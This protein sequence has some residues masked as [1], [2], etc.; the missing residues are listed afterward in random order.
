[1]VTVALVVMGLATVTA[2][3]G[4]LL[5]R[6]DAQLRNIGQQVA[7]Q[8]DLG[9]NRILFNLPPTPDSGLRLP[10]PYVL[11]AWG[12]DGTLVDR[13]PKN[14][15]LSQAPM[16]SPSDLSRN[17][18]FIA[19]GGGNRWRVLVVPGPDNERIVIAAAMTD[20]DSAVSRLGWL[21]LSVGLALLLFVAVVGGI[22]VRRSLRPLAEI[23]KTAGAIADGDLSQRIPERAPQTEVGRLGRALNSMLSQIE[24]AFAA[25]A[26]SEHRALQSEERMRQF[27]A[28]A[29][30][31]LRTPL[32]TIRGFAEL[33]R[34]GAGEP[35]Q[36]IKRI[37]DDA[38]R[39]GLLVEDLLLLARLDQQRP[40]VMEPVELIVLANDAVQAARALAPDRTITLVVAPIVGASGEDRG[41]WVTGDE[42]RLRQ[43]IDNL[44]GNALAHTPPESPVTI[45]LSVADGLAV[46]E[47]ADEGPG[48]TP[49]QSER[50]FERF[51]RADPARSRRSGN[52]GTGLGL[53]IVAAL[54]AAHGG[55]VEVVSAPGAGAT[56]RVRLPLA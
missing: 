48:L 23:E 28:D 22:M 21:I 14:I 9:G 55:T 31:E 29:S 2:L 38:A 1:M 10:S 15:V 12:A 24:A 13:Y 50:V 20:V 34:Q 3:R 19:S 27:V 5:D 16:V 7:S 17:E 26:A 45:S 25:R 37:E 56:F 11:E 52:T 43:V 40:L 36:V 42:S 49:E 32:T 8:V 54:V 51:Y 47:V 30:H 4:Y 46:V 53:A 33:Y 18:L 41:L 6:V 39:M 44:V 35:E